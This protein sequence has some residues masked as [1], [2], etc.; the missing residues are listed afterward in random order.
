MLQNS[1]EP[2]TRYTQKNDK[3]NSKNIGTIDASHLGNTVSIRA[4]FCGSR[5]SG[6]TQLVN[7]LR[8]LP[9]SEQYKPSQSIS[10]SNIEMEEKGFCFSFIYSI[11]CICI[12]LHQKTIPEFVQRFLSLY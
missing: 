10:F 4:I 9:F 6:K 5:G 11:F 12:C 7:L 2:Y 3:T 1:S 8:G